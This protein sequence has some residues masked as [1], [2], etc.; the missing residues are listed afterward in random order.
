VRISRGDGIKL[1]YDCEEKPLEK[2]RKSIYLK[3]DMNKGETI[4]E[5]D[6]SLRCPYIKGS[7]NGQDYFKILGKK[8]SKSKKDED[9]LY[10]DDIVK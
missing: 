5:D 2:M 8:L 3:R 1:V 10:M 9:L 6:L 4:S 7:Y